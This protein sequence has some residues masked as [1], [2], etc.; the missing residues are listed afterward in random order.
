[1]AKKPIKKIIRD[2]IKAVKARDIKVE[3]VYLFG[4]HAQKKADKNSDIDVAVISPDFG[5]DFF[6]ECV[7]LKEISEQVD[8][9]LSPRAYSIDEF[10]KATKGDFLYQEIITKG[11]LVKV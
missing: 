6:D 11:I 3:A 8:Y 1:M 7:L 2:F 4:S 5:R 9:D 10:K